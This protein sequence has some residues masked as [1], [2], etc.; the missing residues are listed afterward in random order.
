MG[1]T[2]KVAIVT[3]AA[4]GIG[5]ATVERLCGAGWKVVA[6]DRDETALAWTLGHDGIRALAADVTEMAANEQMVATAQDWGGGLDALV[7]NAAVPLGGSIDTVSMEQLQTA[8]AVNFYGPV[9]GIKAALPAMRAR[10]G[11]G[12]VVTASMHGIVGETGNWAYVS[13]KHAVVGMVKSLAR[14]L[15]WENI[16]INA[17]CPGLTRDTGMTRDIETQAPAIYDMLKGTVPLQRWAEADEMAAAIEF[18]ISPA[19][20]YINGIALPVDGGTGCGSGMNGPQ[21]GA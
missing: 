19:A 7:L 9:L 4:G 10:G 21:S 20:S 13:T 2:G 18:L 1:S 15:G 8:M 5:R 12:I 6:A 16:R 3:G 14:D 11:G 17:V